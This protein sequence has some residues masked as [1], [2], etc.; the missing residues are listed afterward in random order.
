MS[1]F[2]LGDILLRDGSIQ[3]M[4]P[5]EK[6]IQGKIGPSSQKMIQVI[7]DGGQLFVVDDTPEARRIIKKDLARD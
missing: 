2:T 6:P 5:F 3:G 7:L 4:V 1:Y